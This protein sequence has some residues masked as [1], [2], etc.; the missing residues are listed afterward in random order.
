[1][2]NLETIINTCVRS[3]DFA[4]DSGSRQDL[5]TYQ[6][7]TRLQKISS[8]GFN[9]TNYNISR[10]KNRISCLDSKNSRD[11]IKKAREIDKFS[12]AATGVSKTYLGFL[13]RLISEHFIDNT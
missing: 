9:E 5:F 6:V 7:L 11:F 8:T 1:M 10:I 3:L 13:S 4:T 2:S 12:K